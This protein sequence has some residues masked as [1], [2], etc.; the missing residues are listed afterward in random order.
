MC[1]IIYGVKEG[2][3]LKCSLCPRNFDVEKE[4][5]ALLF[6]HPDENGMVHKFHLC[7]DCEEATLKFH[8][9]LKE[10]YMKV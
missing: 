9:Y 8:S 7:R 3:I 1:I 5:G 6:T 2:E 10:E 4:P